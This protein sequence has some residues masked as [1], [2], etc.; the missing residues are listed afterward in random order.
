MC[1]EVSFE[2]KQNRMCRM[3]SV[4]LSAKSAVGKLNV[5]IEIDE[6]Y[7][8]NVVRGEHLNTLRS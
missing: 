7:F 6:F 8:E 3:Q 5:S 1:T 2:V 4:S